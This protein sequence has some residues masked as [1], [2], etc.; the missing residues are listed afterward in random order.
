VGGTGS[1]LCPVVGFG[2]GDVEPSD[3]AA[4]VCNKFE[5]VCSMAWLVSDE[6][7]CQS[8][9][10]FCQCARK[11]LHFLLAAFCFSDGMQQYVA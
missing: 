4:S 1:E 3:S 11:S 8:Y 2:V 9:S 7:T 5:I 6:D 10:F